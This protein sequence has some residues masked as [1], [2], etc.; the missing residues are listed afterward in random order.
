[1]S[2]DIWDEQSAPTVEACTS[3]E[4]LPSDNEEEDKTWGPLAH[5][6]RLRRQSIRFH[7]DLMYCKESAAASFHHRTKISQWG[8]Y[9]E[10]LKRLK[11]SHADNNYVQKEHFHS[12]LI[13]PPR[14]DPPCTNFTIIAAI[15]LLPN[16][17]RRHKKKGTV[18]TCSCDRSPTK[19]TMMLWDPGVRP[20][21]LQLPKILLFLKRGGWLWSTA[22]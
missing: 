12:K 11:W 14:R 7:Q 4:C 13:V 20:E 8:W 2:N 17:L 10:H 19:S 6:E 18:E 15:T 9:V 5:L 21:L 3:T 16:P 1:M 22:G